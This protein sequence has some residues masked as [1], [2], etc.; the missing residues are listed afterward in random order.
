MYKVKCKSGNA[1]SR[2]QL[3]A[4]FYDLRNFSS[5]DKDN[6]YELMIQFEK[7]R[8]ALFNERSEKIVELVPV[9]IDWINHFTEFLKDW[10]EGKV[11]MNRMEN[12]RDK[13]LRT[14]IH[15]FITGIVVKTGNH[16]TLNYGKHLIISDG[17]NRLFLLGHLYDYAD[18]IKVG[19]RIFPGDTVGY[20]GNSG[21]CAGLSEEAKKDG[22][23]THLHLTVYMTETAKSISNQPTEIMV[24][25][26]NDLLYSDG[27]YKTYSCEKYKN[28][29]PFNYEEKR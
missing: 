19:S 16:K 4:D 5:P 6:V 1:F 29:N 22:S 2:E 14:P 23:G 25:E 17:N 15:S 10:D 13:K 20:V 9:S 11:F 28:I 26:I 3:F 12:A 8:I 27:T 21:N 7:E 24:K 18:G